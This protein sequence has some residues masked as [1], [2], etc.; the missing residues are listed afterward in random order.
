MT[1]NLFLQDQAVSQTLSCVPDCAAR[2]TAGA[3]NFL[4]TGWNAFFEALDEKCLRRKDRHRTGYLYPAGGGA[5]SLGG[6]AAAGTWLLL[7]GVVCG[8]R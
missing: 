1:E 3:G 4:S 8:Q 7:C 6:E 5:Q 2:K